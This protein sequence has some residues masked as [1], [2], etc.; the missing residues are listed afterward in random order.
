MGVVYWVVETVY[1][2]TILHGK[3]G[4][5]AEGTNPEVKPERTKDVPE[6]SQTSGLV[7]LVKT[8]NP[9]GG[10]SVW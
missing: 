9:G 8:R 2:F 3:H 7:Y 1:M 5:S 4:Q 10:E 6:S